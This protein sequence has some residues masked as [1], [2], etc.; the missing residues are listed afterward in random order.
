MIVFLA[1]PPAVMLIVSGLLCISVCLRVVDKISIEN[2]SKQS[3][4]ILHVLCQPRYPLHWLS[5][6]FLQ[7]ARCLIQLTDGLIFCS[8]EQDVYIMCVCAVP[9]KSIFDSSCDY[10]SVPDFGRDARRWYYLVVYLSV[11]PHK[12]KRQ[13]WKNNKFSPFL[14][15]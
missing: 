12:A 8:S 3:T 11:I 1:L 13:I 6:V 9:T 2:R 7:L 14:Q 4:N 15:W 5:G 10:T